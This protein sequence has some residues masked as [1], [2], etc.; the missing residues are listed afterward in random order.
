[1][2]RVG[3]FG[4]CLRAMFGD[5][6]MVMRFQDLS[7]SML[8]FGER[9]IMGCKYERSLVPELADAFDAIDSHPPSPAELRWIR[10]RL[11]HGLEGADLLACRQHA[12]ID[13]FIGS[14]VGRRRAFATKRVGR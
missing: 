12:Y 13:D 7:N 3:L 9:L 10:D 11:A 6:S 5:R 4:K 2:I 1:M 14:A 8:W